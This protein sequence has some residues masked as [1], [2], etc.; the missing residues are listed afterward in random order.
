MKS[1]RSLFFVNSLQTRH[2]CRLRRRKEVPIANAKLIGKLCAL[3]LLPVLATPAVA[4]D[5][6][7]HEKC[8]KAA[9]YK[10]CVEALGGVIVD[11]IRPSTQNIKLNIDT[12]VSADGNECPGEFAYAGAG[13]CRRVVCEYAGLLGMG[14]HPDLAGKGIKCQK[15]IGQ[16]RWGEWDK[17]KVRASVNPICPKI[18]FEVGYQSTCQLATVKGFKF[19]ADSRYN[20]ALQILQALSDANPTNWLAALGVSH[21][22][23]RRGLL[24]E[25]LPYARRAYESVPDGENKHLAQITLAVVLH[26]L[27]PGDRE[28]NILAQKAFNSEPRLR[29]KQYLTKIQALPSE[30]LVIQSLSK[31]P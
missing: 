25:A 23:S 12:Q 16:M 13:Y 22:L 14:H 10:G 27:T 2:S 28:A 4:M 11:Q 29:D 20:E 21:E 30:I 18:P 8:L 15:G 5:A 24:S 19:N 6:G 3:L 7:I 1:I 17:E 31:N 26:S 9:D